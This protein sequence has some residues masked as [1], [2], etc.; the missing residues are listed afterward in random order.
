MGSQILNV[1]PASWHGVPHTGFEA[2]A[3][4]LHILLFHPVPATR[5]VCLEDLQVWAGDR[6]GFCLDMRHHGVIQRV[7][8][9]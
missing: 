9:W 1:V 6:T 2:D 4:T 3:N 5:D 8:I 7:Q